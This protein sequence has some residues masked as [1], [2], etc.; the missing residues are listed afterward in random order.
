MWKIRKMDFFCKNCLAL[1]VSGREQKTRIFVHT[2]CFGP[3]ILLGPR[4]CKPGKTIKI[5][6]SA[7]IGQNQKWHLFFGKRCFFDM[8]E[9]VGV[10]NCVFEKLCFSE[11]TIFI[12]F[13]ANPAFQKQKLYDEKN[14][15]FVKNSGL[16]LN[17]AKRCFGGLFFEVLMLLWF[18]FCVS[19]IVPKVL[20]MR[21]FF[22]VFGAFLG[23]LL[24]A[25]L[26]LEGLGVFVFLVFGFPFGV[27]FVSVCLLCFVLWLDVVVSVS[28]F[29]VCVFFSLL[30]L[31]CF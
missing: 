11:N 31:F 10:T 26:C 18:V 21:V 19:A 17:M 28:V 9:K 24:L 30:F 20:K 22:A 16:F 12:V 8:G 3:K 5:V 15:K 14:R 1:F 2:I 6:V 23:C 29:V 13:S 4:Q 7:E 25:Y 27:C